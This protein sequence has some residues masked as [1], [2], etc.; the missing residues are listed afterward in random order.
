M[1]HALLQ[2]L[3][4]WNKYCQTNCMWQSEYKFRSPD[5]TSVSLSFL[6]EVQIQSWHAGASRDPQKD[7]FFAYREYRELVNSSKAKI[8]LSWMTEGVFCFLCKPL[9]SQDS[10]QQL[11]Q[12]S[13]VRQDTWWHMPHVVQRHQSAA[14]TPPEAELGLSLHELVCMFS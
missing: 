4:S 12:G 3:G 10:S 8:W 13:S 2:R 11:F 6:D 7:L 9:L 1:Y 5:I 14:Y